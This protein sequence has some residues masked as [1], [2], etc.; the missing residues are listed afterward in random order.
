MALKR[1]PLDGFVNQDWDEKETRAQWGC[2]SN[3]DSCVMF[4]TN[5]IQSKTTTSFAL[6]PFIARLGTVSFK[7]L[8]LFNLN[9]GSSLN[10]FPNDP[11]AALNAHRSALRVL[12]FSTSVFNVERVKREKLQLRLP[13]KINSRGRLNLKTWLESQFAAFRSR[14]IERE[15]ESKALRSKLKC[16]KNCTQNCLRFGEV[17]STNSLLLTESISGCQAFCA[18]LAIIIYD[19]LLRRRRRRKN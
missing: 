17:N 19:L 6:P 8:L 13:L 9:H 3:L 5:H 16:Q 2:L 7:K 15:R 12:S 11:S 1:Q 14:R 4:A 18:T 10:Y